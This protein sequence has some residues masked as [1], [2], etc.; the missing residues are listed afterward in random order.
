MENVLDFPGLVIV[1][2]SDN[3]RAAA[4]GCR[5]H[6]GWAALVMVAGGIAQPLVLFRGR[7]DLADPTGRIRRNVYQAARTLDPADAQG[8]GRGSHRA[9]LRSRRRELPQWGAA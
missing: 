6:T 4:L 9:V 5:A 1:S 7:I 8:S 3:A 2:S